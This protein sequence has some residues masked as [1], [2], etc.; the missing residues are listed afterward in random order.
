[1]AKVKPDPKQRGLFRL[2]ITW[3][4]EACFPV[5]VNSRSPNADP[6]KFTPAPLKSP[7]AAVPP[8]PGNISQN[9]CGRQTAHDNGAGGAALVSALAGHSSSANSFYG[10]GGAAPLWEFPLRWRS[11]AADQKVARPPRGNVFTPVEH[12]GPTVL[13]AATCMYLINKR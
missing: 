4:P 6:D 7:G 2:K 3:A 8:T 12:R 13:H 11:R 9:R 1:M 10:A 5:P